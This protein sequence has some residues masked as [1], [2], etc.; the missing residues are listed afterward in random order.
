MGYNKHIKQTGY[1]RLEFHSY[2][3]HHVT[4][5]IEHHT[6]FNRGLS[7]YKLISATQHC[8]CA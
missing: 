5:T 8:I 3:W 6:G 7:L 2:R 4:T 1:A